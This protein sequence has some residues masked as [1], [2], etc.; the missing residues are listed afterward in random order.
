M[1][2]RRTAHLVLLAVVAALLPAGLPM[3]ARAS[4]GTMPGYVTMVSESGDYIGQGQSRTFRD[5]ISVYR[6]DEHLTVAAGPFSFDFEAP[7]GQVLQPARYPDA[8]RYPF[9][10]TGEPGL[11]VGGDGRGCNTLTGYFTVL[12]LAPDR[13]WLVYEQ[14]CEGDG[15]AVYGE[16][17]LGTGLAQRDLTVEAAAMTWPSHYPGVP[18]RPTP[19]TVT[20]S[21]SSTTTVSATMAAGGPDYGIEHSTCTGSLAPGSSCVVHVGF[22]PSRAGIR[23]GLLQVSDSRGNLREATL[24]SVATSGLTRWQMTGDPEE[25]ISAGGSYSFTPIGGARIHAGGTE[26]I[27]QMSVEHADNWFTATFQAPDGA[28]LLPG[29]TYTGATRYPFNSG[30]AG[31]SVSG[32]GRGC[33]TLTGQFTVH[34]A[35][36]A[37]GYLTSFRIA[38]EQHCEGLA[39]ALRGELS[40]RIPDPAA[41]TPDTTAPAPVGNFTASAP[42]PSVDLAWT[43]PTDADWVDTVVIGT[44][45]TSPATMGRLVYD[46]RQERTTVTGF[47]TWQPYTLTIFT[48]DTSGNLSPLR[49]VTIPATTATPTGPPPAPSAPAPP[50]TT[51]PAP[52]STTTPA[53]TTTTSTRVLAL[54]ASRI[55]G[56]RFRMRGIA[57]RWAADA[58]AV[59]QQRTDHGWVKV[60][61]REFS[62]QGNVRFTVRVPRG[63]GRYRLS[64]RVDGRRYTS[65]AIRVGLR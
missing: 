46:G 21:G 48:E 36:Y 47:E 12:D 34:E 33:N 62:D 44:P 63:A 18:V 49:S 38:F 2:A 4:A 29:R 61:R 60:A 27:A 41:P 26:T 64:T 40:W 14:H 19:V 43:N 59:L 53:P 31:L 24:S 30:N 55:E 50:A 23:L 57:G 15:P 65:P 1:S 13:I 28:I 32:S 39:P 51:A 58:R 5:N 7:D 42:G 9:Q 6:S 11:D 37:D 16:I 3:A 56:R 54:K 22:T 20:N 10:E 35:T 25:Y 52:S 8:T 45:G 17:R